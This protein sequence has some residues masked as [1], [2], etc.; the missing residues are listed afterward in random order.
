MAFNVETSASL[1]AMPMELDINIPTTPR[2]NPDAIVPADTLVPVD[3]LVPANHSMPETSMEQ[4][5][6]TDPDILVDDGLPK[7]PPELTQPRELMEPREL[8]E[9]TDLTEPIEPSPTDLVEPT[10]LGEPI[11]PS[12]PERLMELT[13]PATS[14]RQI[15]FNF[16]S[17]MA[18][19][20]KVQPRLSRSPTPLS[21]RRKDG[22]A[23]RLRNQDT[24]MT[25]M[26]ET[27]VDKA[28]LIPQDVL[29]TRIAIQEKDKS[30]ELL[31]DEASDR[32]L[33]MWREINKICEFSWLRIGIV[34]SQ[35]WRRWK[36]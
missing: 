29:V 3:A 2:P 7:E 33:M 23:K 24:N 27:Q 25:E 32:L 19:A 13:T 12:P 22:R 1:P 28:R 15:E 17:P 6:T 9:P 10:D 31:K 16:T 35:R 36:I 11:Q 21:D 26:T 4:D 5:M 14:S 8:T 20:R 18:H 30:I 34:C